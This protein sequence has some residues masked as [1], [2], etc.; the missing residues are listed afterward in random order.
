VTVEIRDQTENRGMQDRKVKS[1]LRVNQDHKENRAFKVPQV[2]RDSLELKVIPEVRVFKELREKK[3]QRV[4][5]V[6]VEELFSMRTV[7]LTFLPCF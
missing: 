6:L 1:V 4:L 3:A 7:F 2:H 5:L